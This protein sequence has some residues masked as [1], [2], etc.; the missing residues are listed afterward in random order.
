[1]PAQPRGVGEKKRIRPASRTSG[2]LGSFFWRSGQKTGGLGSVE[3]SPC[4]QWILRRALSPS[5]N[6]SA[7]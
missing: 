1:L 3:R 7:S 5:T 2:A 6:A 4:L